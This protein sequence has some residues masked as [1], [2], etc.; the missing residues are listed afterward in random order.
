[1][2]RG[3][4]TPFFPM[5]VPP[6]RNLDSS[7]WADAFLACCYMVLA[8]QGFLPFSLCLSEA[9]CGMYMCTAEM[10]FSLTAVRSLVVPQWLSNQL[11][12]DKLR[13]LRC[14]ED[15]GWTVFLYFSALSHIAVSPSYR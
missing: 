12:A 14:L 4:K 15:V 9:L 6:Q 3:V 7:A 13:W 2:R 11:A 8:I 1:M 5:P 10:S